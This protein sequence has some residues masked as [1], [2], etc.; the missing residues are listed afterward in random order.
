MPAC[1][2]RQY[3][4]AVYSQNSLPRA[5]DC[6]LREIPLFCCV[7]S[8]KRRHTFHNRIIPGRSVRHLA[9]EADIGRFTLHKRAESQAHSLNPIIPNRLGSHCFQLRAGNRPSL[10][11]VARIEQPQ[12]STV[13]LNTWRCCCSVAGSDAMTLGG[14]LLKLTSQPASN[15]T[16]KSTAANRFMQNLER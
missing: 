7:P 3:S 2:R 14:L 5:I 1:H 8:G 15:I 9:G 11:N 16:D 6:R 4:R 10:I 12:N 13:A